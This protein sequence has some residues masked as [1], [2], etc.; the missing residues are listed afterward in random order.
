MLY[1]LGQ[2][3]YQKEY[4]KLW[5]ALVPQSGQADTIQGEL[6]RAIGRL[7]SEYERNG[8]ANWDMGFRLYTNFLFKHLRDK[9]VFTPQTLHQIEADLQAIRYFGSRRRNPVS[10]QALEELVYE[11]GEDAFDRI[12]DRVMQWCQHY[13]DPIKHAH[14]P[15]LKR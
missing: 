12:T 8:N 9:S 2:G 6:I 14:N 15:K 5:D 13:P 4:D 10:E 1:T 7:T 3:R 11:K